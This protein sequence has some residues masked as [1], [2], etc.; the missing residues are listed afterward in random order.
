M[1]ILE[2][3]RVD[4]LATAVDPSDGVAADPFAEWV[5][6]ARDRAELVHLHRI[7]ARA[8]V[9][10]ELERP[11]APGIWEALGV[12]ALWSHQA[13]ALDLLRNRRSAV[14][15]TGTGSGKSLIYQA[16]MA[17]AVTAPIRP[18]TALALFPTKALAQ[19]QARALRSLDLRRLAVGTYDGDCTADERTWARTKANVVLTNPEML[20]YG[21]LPN[22][23]K[24]ST[25]L[26]RLA[27]VVVDELHLLRGVFGSHVAHVLRRLRRLCAHYGAVPTFAFTSATIGEPAKLARDLCGLD[28]TAV[29]EDGSPRSEKLFALWNPPVLDQRD[30]AATP[31]RASAGVEAAVLSAGLIAD[32]RRTIVFARSR[33]ATEVIAAD[34]QRRLPRAR[35]DSVRPYRSGYLAEE[36][37]E[38]ELALFEGELSGIVTT[39]ALELG[40]DVAG[41]DTA[42][43][44]GFPGTVSSM[45]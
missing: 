5:E 33:R 16:A 7:E 18:R 26:G 27:Y 25:F 17:E 13:E 20:H 8:G 41:L 24:W 21:L 9:T 1:A 35:R 42:V 43:M 37:R 31:K 3:V 2:Q 28:V 23:R 40:I 22:H 12:G 36:R 45:W 11:L 15:A 44:A 29:T 39:S 14:V 6:S 4:P 34:I 10:A 32:G 30:G 38:I 19:D